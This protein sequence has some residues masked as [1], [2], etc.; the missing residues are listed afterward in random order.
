MKFLKKILYI[1]ECVLFV[2]MVLVGSVVIMIIAALGWIYTN[3]MRVF[4][5]EQV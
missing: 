4:S 5:N 1:L 3:M 2:I